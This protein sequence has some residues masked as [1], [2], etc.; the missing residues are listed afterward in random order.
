MNKNKNKK[1]IELIRC[2]N[3]S[4]PQNHNSVPWALLTL[5]NR[6]R[7]IICKGVHW[8][9]WWLHDDF[10]PWSQIH[11]GFSSAVLQ[12]KSPFSSFRKKWFPTSHSRGCPSSVSHFELHKVHSSRRSQHLSIG[13]LQMHNSSI[14]WSPKKI[15]NL[16]MSMYR[17]QRISFWTA[18]LILEFTYSVK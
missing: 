4:F 14:W 11:K 13:I 18:I 8:S 9:P 12:K 7:V 2:Q 16:L 6:L 5:R 3:S 17:G 15:T 1:R 10:C